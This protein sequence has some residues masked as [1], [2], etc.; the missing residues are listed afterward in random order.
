MLNFGVTVLPDPPHSRLL[1]LLQRAEAYGFEHGWTYDLHILWQE[2]FALLPL[3]T[4][5]TTRLKL[6]PL[7]H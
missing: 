5:A 3:A 2:L 1:E 6:G 7:R 4:A